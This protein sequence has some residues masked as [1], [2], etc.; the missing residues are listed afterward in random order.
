MRTV[1]IVAGTLSLAAALAPVRS[2]AVA[3]PVATSVPRE[4]PFVDAVE[5][6]LRTRGIDYHAQ[7]RGRRET[8]LVFGGLRGTDDAAG[9][10]T[11]GDRTGASAAT[12]ERVPAAR[13]T[14]RILYR[15]GV[16][17]AGCR[18]QRESTAPLH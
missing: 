6:W 12:S 3:A 7:S 10:A 16:P 2:P 18:R 8:T 13:R 1:V 5:A 14:V 17:L 15:Y 11:A 4:P 9:A